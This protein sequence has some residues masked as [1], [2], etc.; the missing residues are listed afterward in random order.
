MGHGF[1]FSFTFVFL[2]T[3]LCFT[4]L[5]CLDAGCD[6]FQGSWVYD[7]AYPLYDA[8]LCS[9]IEKQ[10]DCVG[11]GRPDRLYLKYRWKPNACELPKYGLILQLMQLLPN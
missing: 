6:L 7:D 5:S 11:N 4:P 9:F 3:V 8:S 1:S 2:L 10:F